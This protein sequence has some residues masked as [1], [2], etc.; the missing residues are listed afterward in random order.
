VV[1]LMYFSMLIVIQ[2]NIQL[3]KYINDTKYVIV[4]ILQEVI[5]ST[6]I[7]CH[8]SIFQLGSAHLARSVGK[9]TTQG[10]FYSHDVLILHLLFIEFMFLVLMFR[11]WIYSIICEHD[12]KSATC[13]LTNEHV[14]TL[15]DTCHMLCSSLCCIYRAKS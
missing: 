12:T 11:H 4:L 6:R 10:T 7:C 13:Q 5:L 1:I 14:Q 2:Y 9:E 3:I 15:A 8:W